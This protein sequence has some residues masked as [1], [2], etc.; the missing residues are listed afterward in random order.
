MKHLAIAAIGFWILFQLGRMLW[1]S[2]D[3]GFDEAFANF[4][5]APRRSIENPYHNGYFYLF[6]LTAAAPLDPAKTGYEIWVEESEEGRR[7]EPD[8][9][10]ANRSNLAFALSPESETPAWEDDDPLNEFRKKDARPRDLTSKHEILLTRYEHWLGMPFDDWGFGRR[11]VPLGKDILAIHRLYVAE[12]FSLSTVQ[13]LERLRKDLQLWRTVLLD[14]KTIGMKVLA[15]VV[16]TDDLQLLSRILAKPTVDKAIITMGLQL[17]LPLSPSEYS[18]RWPIRNQIALAVKDSRAVGIR[19]H[20]QMDRRTSHDEWLLQAAHL[21][22]HAFDSVEHPSAPSTLSV[23]LQS[24]QA[25]KTYAA[26]YEAVITASENNSKSLPQLQ[27]VIGTI[28]RGLIESVLN[29]HPIE[30][31]WGVFY[32]QL[33][34]TDT[35]LRLASLQIQL[36]RQSAQIAVPTRLAEVGSQYFDPFTGLP[37]LWSPTQQKLYSVGKDRLDDG[38]DPTF[39]ISVP[40]VIAQ[41][42]LKP[43]APASTTARA[44]RR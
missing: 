33:V 16:I 9:S 7:N 38:G 21:P 30:P 4:L 36:L 11:V 24:G 6:G 42:P 12:G 10:R 17:T 19:S 43:T 18:L 39:D 5:D 26:Y 2:N 25:S 22:V 31:N 13:G 15:E 40:A 3:H 41:L 37:M 29:P 8:E 35:R 34:E 20:S 44:S 1:S 28:P 27:E 23:I 14:A 32:H